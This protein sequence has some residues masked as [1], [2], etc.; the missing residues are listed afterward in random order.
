MIFTF[1]KEN[2][3]EVPDNDVI[4]YIK[5]LGIKRIPDHPGEFKK[6]VTGFVFDHCQRLSR[7]L[8]DKRHSDNDILGVIDNFNWIKIDKE[9][10]SKLKTSYQ[11]KKQRKYKNEKRNKVVALRTLTKSTQ[12]DIVK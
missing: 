10:L 5:N 2:N 12:W 9:N 3:I 1:L 8:F 11:N 6:P 7:C 4:N